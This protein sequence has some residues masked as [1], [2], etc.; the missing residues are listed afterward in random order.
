MLQTQQS[1]QHA[2]ATEH[3][4]SVLVSTKDMSTVK[5]SHHHEKRDKE[6]SDVDNNAEFLVCRAQLVDVVSCD[7]C[8][9]RMRPSATNVCALQLPVYAAFSC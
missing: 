9:Q 3:A 1:M 4:C 6:E 8:L 5:R 2:T 7:H